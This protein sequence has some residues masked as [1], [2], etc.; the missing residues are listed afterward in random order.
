MIK[1]MAKN[2]SKGIDN[3]FSPT[4]D[5]DNVFKATI[6][7]LDETKQV[8]QVNTNVAG[9]TPK[10]EKKERSDATV[11]YNIRYSKELQKRIKRFCIEHDGVDMKDVFTRGAEMYLN[12]N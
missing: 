6:K 7:E 3:V 2:F 9:I 10:I 4:V 5:T 12:C 8:N 11:C 1:E